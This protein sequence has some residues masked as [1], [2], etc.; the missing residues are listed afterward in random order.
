MTEFTTEIRES[1]MRFFTPDLFLRFN[2]EDD[3]VADAAHEEWEL[4]TAEYHHN[5]KKVLRNAS[6]SIRKLSDL[7]FHDAEVYD[8]SF[9]PSGRGGSHP[10]YIAGPRIPPF[11]SRPTPATMRLTLGNQSVCL[12]YFLWDGLIH[13]SP[14]PNWPERQRSL[15]W[16]YDEIDEIWSNFGMYVHRILFSNGFI[17]EIP[18]YDVMIIDSLKSK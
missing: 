12:I 11:V 4:L 10:A 2:S 7:C 13:N 9:D 6:E 8:L 1:P 16:L 15:L 18:F 5:L 17:V 14:V 3:E